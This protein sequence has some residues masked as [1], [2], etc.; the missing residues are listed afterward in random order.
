[1]VSRFLIGSSKVEVQGDWFFR[2]LAILSFQGLLL[3]FSP[4]FSEKKSWRGLLGHCA[5]HGSG[6][7]THNIRRKRIIKSR[8]A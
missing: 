4:G 2:M 1:M 7:F 8:V 5:I 3:G 6:Y